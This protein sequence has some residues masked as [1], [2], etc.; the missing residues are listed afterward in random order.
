MNSGSLF[1]GDQ[2]YGFPDSPVFAVNLTTAGVAHIVAGK[3]KVFAKGIDLSMVRSVQLLSNLGAVERKHV[4]NLL[5]VDS[6][7]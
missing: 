4:Q 7:V 3:Q 1:C 6:F 2:R 5:P